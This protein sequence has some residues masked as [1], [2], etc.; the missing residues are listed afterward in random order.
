MRLHFR[1]ESN[2]N[3]FPFEVE[4]ELTGKVWGLFGPSGAGKTSLLHFLAGIRRPQR[5]FLKLDDEILWDEDVNLPA[6]QRRIA[7]VFQEN[8]L[9]PHLNVSGNLRYGMALRGPSRLS[10]EEVVNTLELGHLLRARPQE[11]SGGEGQRVS[12]GRAL[13]SSPRLIL[14][15]EPMASLDQALKKQILPFLRRVPE[16][17]GI[18][19]IHVS[20]DLGEMLQL[21]QNLLMLRGGQLLA[22]GPFTEIIRRPEVFELVHDMGLLNVVRMTLCEKQVNEGLTLLES[23]KGKVVWAGPPLSEKNERV[24]YV[25][26]RPED[27]ALVGQ[28]VEGISM[29]NQIPGRIIDIVQAR[30]RALCMVDVGFTL[31]AEITPEALLE[32]GL[33]PGSEVRCLFKAHALRYLDNN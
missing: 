23:P 29:R 7:V 13:L 28:Q 14:L 33:V 4:C 6:W 32:L 5:G 15:D 20:H 25:G 26:L 18:P 8:R 17:L 2:L 24:V 16:E 27:I 11:L 12:L 30:H 1:F 19:L 31:M 9:F 3:G 10:F 22:K 21:T